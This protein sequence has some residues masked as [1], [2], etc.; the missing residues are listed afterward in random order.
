MTELEAIRIELDRLTVRSLWAYLLD[1]KHAASEIER[2][3][4]EL[5]QRESELMRARN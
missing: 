5:A 1:A 4:A 2:R 3:I